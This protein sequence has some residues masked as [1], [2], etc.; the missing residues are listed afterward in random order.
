VN[1]GHECALRWESDN[2]ESLMFGFKEWSELQKLA[3]RAPGKPVDWREG[4]LVR[5]NL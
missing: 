5:S 1:L 4:E 3:L 2:G